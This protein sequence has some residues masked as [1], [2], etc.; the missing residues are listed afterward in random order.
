MG[1]RSLNGESDGKGKMKEKLRLAVFGHKRWSREG[2]VEIVVK[3]LCTR[4]AQNGCD[5]TCYNRAGHHVSGAEYDDVTIEYK[6]IHQKT[7]PTIN[8]R[9]A[10][11][12][13]GST[14]KTYD[15]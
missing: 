1:M 7:V 2:G 9:G 4:M 15:N 3:E 12:I 14:K 8:R 13:I 5:V 11:D 10:R 6:G